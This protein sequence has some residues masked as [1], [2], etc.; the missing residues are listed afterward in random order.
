MGVL[1]NVNIVDSEP[2][3]QTDSASRVAHLKL[4]K[5]PFS[6]SQ[7]GAV[8]RGRRVLIIEDESSVRTL[9]EH[10]FILEGY[11][12]TVAE[13]GNEGVASFKELRHDLVFTDLHIPGMS[14]TEVARSIKAESPNTPVIAI[15][16]W[17]T[18]LS[19]V[20]MSQQ[21]FD[22]IVSKPFE[23]EQLLEMASSLTT[24]G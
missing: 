23:L 1:N 13:D 22:F 14:G 3:Q 5:K 21:T 2:K 8:D 15:T 6:G 19:G 16:G 10:M 24:K 7:A 18:A 11:Q 17:G 20:D 4:M 12:T 9:L